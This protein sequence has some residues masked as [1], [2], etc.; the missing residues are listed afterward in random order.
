MFRPWALP[1]SND[2]NILQLPLEGVFGEVVE[3]IGADA[4]F[5]L[6]SSM[7]LS[8]TRSWRVCFYVPKRLRVDHSLVRILGWRDA[9]RLSRAFGGEILQTSNLRNHERAWR[10]VSIFALHLRSN[11]SVH[12]IAEELGV[13]RTTVAKTLAGKPPEGLSTWF[14]LNFKGLV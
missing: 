12:R 10:S 11:A 6:V 8:T 3:S 5:I 1:V 13:D 7:R 14:P 4:A 9:T 2:D